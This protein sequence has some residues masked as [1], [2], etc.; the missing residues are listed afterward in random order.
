MCS[1]SPKPIRPMAIDR[2]V[3]S[4]IL[5]KI[6]IPSKWPQKKKKKVICLQLEC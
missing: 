3:H 6:P 1:S 4:P 5:K 2:L